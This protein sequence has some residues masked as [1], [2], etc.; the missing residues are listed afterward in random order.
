MWQPFRLLFCLNKS[1]QFCNWLF[2]KL[3][4]AAQVVCIKN[5]FYVS[6]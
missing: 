1:V 6:Q 3:D 4:L 5:R 2:S